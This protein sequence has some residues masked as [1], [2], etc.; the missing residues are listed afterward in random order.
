M[1]RASR[2]RL[3]LGRQ[4]WPCA[5]GILVGNELELAN[6]IW[7]SE[8]QDFCGPRLQANRPYYRWI[9]P[10]QCPVVVEWFGWKVHW[11]HERVK[12]PLEWEDVNERRI[13]TGIFRKDLPKKNWLVCRSTGRIVGRSRCIYD[14]YIYTHTSLY[15]LAQVQRNPPNL[16]TSSPHLGRNFTPPEEAPRPT[17][18]STGG[19]SG[20]RGREQTDQGEWFSSDQLMEE[21][22]QQYIWEYLRSVGICR[23]SI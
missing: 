10:M 19:L 22:P 4:A 18:R 9:E 11:K 13:H 15:L 1:S 21:D 12:N 5:G 2:T 20:G 7:E 16:P 3:D 8:D 23:A 6:W 17:G 14:I